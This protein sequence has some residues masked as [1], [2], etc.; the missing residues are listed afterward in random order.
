[1]AEVMTW[2]MAGTACVGFL[3]NVSVFIKCYK[4]KKGTRNNA[5]ILITS[6]ACADITFCLGIMV[7][8]IVV[9]T[10]FSYS[11][12]ALSVYWN[13]SQGASFSGS[14]LHIM[15]IAVDRLIAVIMPV[16]YKNN[17]NSSLKACI[18]LSSIWVMSFLIASTQYF[19]PMHV[20]DI[21]VSVM[22][23]IASIEAIFVYSVIGWRL[24]K[25][26]ISLAVCK[27][28]RKKLMKSY[29][30]SVFLCALLTIAFFGFNIPFVAY[31]VYVIVTGKDFTI[32]ASHIL[33]YLMTLNCVVDPII[34]NFAAN[35]LKV[36]RKKCGKS[37]INRPKSTQSFK[38]STLLSS[39]Y[40]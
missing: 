17:S 15:T 12:K 38:R 25:R 4:K 30:K 6:L 21:V 16:Y 27:E 19:L 29:R 35:L 31:N 39:T 26:T 13:L 40:L 36:I 24:Y 14:L 32:T 33:Y 11:R 20:I 5:D 9:I 34:Y 10:G 1:M 28:Q 2:F 22:I 23:S 8:S 7:N 3:L 37:F 18:V